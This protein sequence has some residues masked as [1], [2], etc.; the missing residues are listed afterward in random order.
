MK[1]PDFVQTLL[2]LQQLQTP[3]PRGASG[4]SRALGPPPYPGSGMSGGE[5]GLEPEPLLLN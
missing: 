3:W 2:N 5:E 4:K 1:S